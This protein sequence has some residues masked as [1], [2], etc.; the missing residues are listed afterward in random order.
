MR[1]K[2]WERDRETEIKREME[3]EE[4]LRKGREKKS[5]NRKVSQIYRNGIHT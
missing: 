4:R 3:R 2:E 1:E 5:Y